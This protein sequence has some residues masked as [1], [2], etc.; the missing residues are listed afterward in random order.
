[1]NKGKLL[2]ESFKEMGTV[3][4]HSSKEKKKTRKFKL[5]FPTEV[6]RIEHSIMILSTLHSWRK[7]NILKFMMMKRK[8]HHLKNKEKSPK[9]KPNTLKYLLSK[10]TTIS[11]RP[12][13]DISYKEN[14]TLTLNL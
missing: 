1:M 8:L 9:S 4:L 3:L 12:S 2:L 6:P 14:S 7:M 5:K 11:E 10:K 13:L